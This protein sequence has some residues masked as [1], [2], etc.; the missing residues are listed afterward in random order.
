MTSFVEKPKT[1]QY[2]PI[3]ATHPSDQQPRKDFE[4]SRVL[5]LYVLRTPHGTKP[6]DSL[7]REIYTLYCYSPIAPLAAAMLLV[8]NGLQ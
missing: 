5:I 8:R 3:N 2:Y 6:N 7:L 4:M 1:Q